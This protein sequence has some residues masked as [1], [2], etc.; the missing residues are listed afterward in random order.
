VRDAVNAHGGSDGVN[1]GVQGDGLKANGLA[2]I[3]VDPA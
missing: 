3:Q 1:G 2:L